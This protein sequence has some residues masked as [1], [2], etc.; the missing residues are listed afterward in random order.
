MNRRLSVVAAL[1]IA[2][3][4]ALVVAAPASAATL[5]PTDTLYAIPCNSADLGL[6]ELSTTDASWVN[7]IP[8]QVITTSECAYQPAFNP[9]TGAS[10]FLAGNTADGTWPLV[11]IDIATGNYTV[12]HEIWDGT[13]NVG[14]NFGADNFP[15][16]LLITNG[17]AAYFLGNK[18]L[19]PLDLA[20]GI[21]GAQIGP[22]LATTNDI[23]GAACSPVNTICYVL[24][25]V[26]AFY[27]LDVATGTLGPL[28]GTIPAVGNYSLQVASDGTL[29]ASTGGGV[30]AS[31]SAADPAGSYEAIGQTPLYS[32]AYLITG[33][34]T[35]PAVLPPAAT[36]ALA[37]TGTDSA[38][39]VLGGFAVLAAGALLVLVA[40]RR[41]VSR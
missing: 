26:G 19:Y 2:A 33:A 13:T 22:D 36:P 12:I 35:A 8:N 24:D 10:Y 3:P 1:A 41:A 9:A 39:P 37:A 40:R 20:S 34:F 31:F 7:V 32:G 4:L 25:E 15:G 30:L 23:Y 27:A 18:N 29:W 11:R 28:L 38:A 16:N 21:I 14:L 17:G 6:Y 5:P